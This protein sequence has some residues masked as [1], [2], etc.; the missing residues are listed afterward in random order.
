MK[1]IFISLENGE[2]VLIYTET[3]TTEECQKF[4][5]K[6]TGAKV[7]DCYPIEDNE[8]QL[9]C[10]DGRIWADTPEKEAKVKAII[11]S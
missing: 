11:N 5:D 1:N 8:I 7:I 3:L 2:N 10:L 6:T 4:A 9:Y